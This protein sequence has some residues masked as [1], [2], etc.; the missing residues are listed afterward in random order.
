MSS[1][2]IKV[3]LDEASS[4]M[5]FYRM[6]GG[7]WCLID[8][9][10]DDL[11]PYIQEDASSDI[12]DDAFFSALRQAAFAQSGERLLIWFE[13]S[14][15]DYSDFRDCL[16]DCALDEN[17]RVKRLKTEQRDKKTGYSVSE[18]D[19]FLNKGETEKSQ[20]VA[21]TTDQSCIAC[22]PEEVHETS[23]LLLP[24]KDGIF[25]WKKIYPPLPAE[26]KQP[27]ILDETMNVTEDTI[28]IN[29]I[30]HLK[31]D[32]T[33]EAKVECIHCLIYIGEK[34]HVHIQKEAVLWLK[35]CMVESEEDERQWNG[36]EKKDCLVK[37]DGELHIYGGS[38]SNLTIASYNACAVYS[39]GILH[40]AYTTFIDCAGNFIV[41]KQGISAARI[42]TENFR[43]QFLLATGS[44]IFDEE[45]NGHNF[46]Y[47]AFCKFDFSIGNTKTYRLV[48]G[49]F[50]LGDVEEARPFLEMDSG[51]LMFCEFNQKD[52]WNDRIFVTVKNCYIGS[53][54]FNRCGKIEAENTEFEENKF[55]RCLQ[56]SAGGK[57]TWKGC[58]F[59]ECVQLCGSEGA[60]IDYYDPDPD[61]TTIFENC[62][63]ERCV[64]GRL[65]SFAYGEELEQYR[66]C[67]IEGNTFK[68][69][70][71]AETLI[72]GSIDEKM[73]SETNS[74]VEDNTFISCDAPKYVVSEGVYGLFK[75]PCCP[76]RIGA[77]E[78]DAELTEWT[79]QIAETLSQFDL[80]EEYRDA[81]QAVCREIERLHEIDDDED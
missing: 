53:C 35:S 56:I 62:T 66:T 31:T 18:K 3:L 47:V 55:T 34:A 26:Y 78:T 24:P 54:V 8:D 25:S 70:I 33:L 12:W 4:E 27:M 13:G 2:E 68:E 75:K 23:G 46:N 64:V 63:M 30:V 60:F 59:K 9:S 69:C 39:Q 37:V 36:R 76:F 28:L 16:D 10:D 20:I 79:E 22:V 71:A 43:G 48:G 17:I 67:S 81:T 45:D 50:N 52:V 15:D 80:E 11:R 74:V 5:S 57:M 49:G 38:T 72:Y 42:R 41:S 7:R 61:Y 58:N 6:E 32:I 1:K 65:L 40:L 51:S 77:N 14:S 21:M 29:K 19:T 73:S 44:S